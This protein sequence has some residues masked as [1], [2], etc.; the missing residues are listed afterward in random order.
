M[1]PPTERPR[2]CGPSFR[3]SGSEHRATS[4]GLIVRRNEG[5]RLAS[6][7]VIFSIDD[8]ATF[9]SPHTI[10]QTLR[11]F[12]SPQ[13]APSPFL[14]STFARINAFADS[15]HTRTRYTRFLPTLEPLTRSDERLF[16]SL[17]GYREIF[18]TRAK[19]VI[20]ASA[21]S[22]RGIL[23]ALAQ[24]TPFITSSPPA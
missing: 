22:T 21:F 13:I 2:C 11:E 6:A 14:L 17:G 15:P 19:K 12:A 18:F 23:S 5:A 9:P 7:P 8:D 24:P 16:L 3:R 4:A 20:F 10:Q 1:A